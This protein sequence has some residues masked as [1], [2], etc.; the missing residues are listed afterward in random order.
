MNERFSNSLFATF[1]GALLFVL[2]GL[3]LVCNE[4]PHEWN[5]PLWVQGTGIFF[6]ATMLTL[7]IGMCLGWIQGFPRWSYPYVG[8]MLVFS[9]YMTMVATPGFKVFGYEVFGRQLWGWRAWIPLMVVALIVF[10][11]T[12]SVKPII[13][14]FTNAREDWTLLTFGMFGFMP[15][16]IAIMF[17]E[18]DR[19]YSLYFMVALTIIMVGTAIVYL[20][21]EN[22]RGRVKTLLVGVALSLAIASIAP[23]IYWVGVLSVNVLPALIAGVIVFL[24]M[25]SPSLLSL[26]QKRINSV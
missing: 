7:P 13:K 17:D 15:L 23:N 25:F 9:W 10:A 12:R 11:V 14:F 21:S 22:Y 1:A 5:V 16:L 6:M 4:F 24:F 19:L 18:V 8:H 20:R 3:E 26:G 2:W